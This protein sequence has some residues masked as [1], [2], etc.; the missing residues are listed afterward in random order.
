MIA[1]K[2]QFDKPDSGNFNLL[3]VVEPA[4]EPAGWLT[5]YMQLEHRPPQENMAIC[6]AQAFY[7]DRPLLFEAGTGVGKSLA[8]LIP[9]VIHAVANKRQAVISTHTIALQ[10]Q[11]IQK[12]IPLVRLFCERIPELKRFAEFKAAQLVGR[13][14][15]L[16][17]SRLAQAGQSKAELFPTPQQAELE[18]LREWSLVA[19]R[20]TLQEL[21]PLPDPEVWDWVNAD[22]ASCNPR[23]CSPDNCFYQRARKQVADSQLIVV[24][25][26]LLFALIGAGAGVRGETPGVLFAR[27]FLIL[28]EAHTVPAVAT[29]HFGHHVSKVG[30]DRMLKRLYNPRNKKGLFKKFGSSYDVQATAEAIATADSFF[31]T[32]LRERLPKSSVVRLR[33]PAWTEATLLPRLADLEKRVADQIQKL[34]E[35]S[36][37][38]DELQDAKRR[39]G[40]ARHA[41]LECI[42]LA[43]EE[44]VYWLEKTGRRQ[45]NVLIRS[46]PLDIA[47][48]LRQTI[49]E[50]HTSALLT[51]ATLA[52]GKDMQSFA[53]KVG[54]A[55]H[56]TEIE[57]SPFDYAKNMQVYV[58]SD[59][60]QPTRGGYVRDRA[61]L[62]EPS[63]YI[64]YLADMV[65]FCAQRVQGGT[66]VLFT[67]YNDLNQVANAIARPLH[68]AGRELLQQGG[69]QSRTEL[70][71][72]M[73]ELGNAVLLGTD[74]FY[75]GVD[76]PGPALSQVIL[77]RLPF[78]N[79]SQPVPEARAER[80]TEEGGNPFLEMTVPDAI[81]KFRQG[82]GRL[83]RKAD[84]KGSITILDSRLLNKQYGR[85]F[86]DV[87]PQQQWQSFDRGNRESVFRT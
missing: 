85:L 21:D 74:S 35:D 58:A 76:I 81:I 80:I 43:D 17:N 64:K 87:L 18:R 8:Y 59:C 37:G 48:E 54:A 19:K 72:Q 69:G 66:L 6:A 36:P 68:E 63:N 20:G 61:Q 22:S 57:G 83:I 60:P 41:L 5:D 77:V 65:Q 28:D 46:A 38:R 79:P 3:Q 71:R 33:D 84:D 78:E 11:L 34:G 82:I 12:D 86:L 62:P 2:E 10:E 24:N 23:N 53:Q 45:S 15:Y 4:F 73:Q 31:N 26:S 70:V 14:N 44:Q 55:G 27:D 49:F 29:D 40:T 42:E 32:I 9:A 50:R 16:C 51:S 30:V 25:H 1:L 13:G 52:E 47:P 7:G 39:L 56:W 75:T 67:S